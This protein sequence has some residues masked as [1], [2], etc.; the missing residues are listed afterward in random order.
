LTTLAVEP[1]VR[2][3]FERL[4]FAPKPSQ[5]ARSRILERWQ[6]KRKG[7]TAPRYDELSLKELVA[8]EPQAFV[9][10]RREGEHDYSL[11][12]QLTN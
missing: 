4:D 8:A 6:E 3:W 2:R 12:A 7:S 10:K 5:G 1:P 11:M 9:F